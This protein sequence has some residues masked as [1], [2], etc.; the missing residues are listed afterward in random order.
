MSDSPYSR[1]AT[2]RLLLSRRSALISYLHIYVRDYYVAED[3]FQEVALRAVERHPDIPD[4][5]SAYAWLRTVARNCAIDWLRRNQRQ[6]ITLDD[7]TL[8]LLDT[9]WTQEK[10]NDSN[11][12]HEALSEC[13]N[14]LT[15]RAQ[16]LVERRF[17]NQMSTKEIAEATGRKTDSIYTAF[18][19]I[20]A[21]LA[22][23]LRAKIPSTEAGHG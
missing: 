14:Q 10:A 2:L 17:K 18:S 11:E 1:E 12:L 15:P 3:L 8:D 16:Q 13:I 19:R 4:E 6:P 21:A 22:D 7:E 5:A 23:C 20:Y 9:Q